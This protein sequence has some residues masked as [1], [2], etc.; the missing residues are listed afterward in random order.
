[1]LLVVVVASH[2]QARVVGMSPSECWREIAELVARRSGGARAVKNIDGGDMFGLSYVSPVLLDM[3]LTEYRKYIR[4]DCVEDRNINL[5][6]FLSFFLFC[7]VVWEIFFIH[8]FFFHFPIVLFSRA[9][10]AGLSNPSWLQK[11]PLQKRKR[12]TNPKFTELPIKRRK[13]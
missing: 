11:K 1:M 2:S 12:K 13:R 4:C 8:F 9:R 5:W 3:L 7:F 6:F 10:P